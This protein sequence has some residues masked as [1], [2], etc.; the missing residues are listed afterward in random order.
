MA[1][2]QLGRD[3]YALRSKFHRFGTTTKRVG[4]F[5]RPMC[6][7]DGCHRDNDTL[8]VTDDDELD[9]PMQTPELKRFCTVQGIDIFRV[10]EI[11]DR[12]TKVQDSVVWPCTETLLINRDY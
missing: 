12:A 1:L 11:G 10:G 9:Y 4:S 3:L 5:N 2:L 8:E 6:T 7:G